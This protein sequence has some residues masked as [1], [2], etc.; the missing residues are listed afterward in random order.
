MR[1]KA[2]KPI[3]LTDHAK[4]YRSQ[5]G[6]SENEVAESIETGPWQSAE[7]DRF[8]SAKEFPF[9]GMWNGIHYQMKKVRTIFVEENDEI[10]VIT[11]Y[12]YYY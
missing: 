10:V 2:E 7:H 5:R 8:E 4:A 11:G 9:D 1:Q 6:F 12:V 3:R